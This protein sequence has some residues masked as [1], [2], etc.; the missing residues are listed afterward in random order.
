MSATFQRSCILAVSALGVSGY[1]D[2]YGYYHGYGGDYNFFAAASVSYDSSYDYQ[3]EEGSVAD[4]AGAEGSCPAEGMCGV[5]NEEP[6]TLAAS[7]QAHSGRKPDSSSPP[8]Q[9]PQDAGT[10]TLVRQSRVVKLK[11][12]TPPARRPQEQHNPSW[13]SWRAEY[14]PAFVPS[15]GNSTKFRGVGLLKQA[16]P[17]DLRKQLVSAYFSQA[18]NCTSACKQQH[19]VDVAGSNFCGVTVSKQLADAVL[20]TAEKALRA[21]SGEDLVVIPSHGSLFDQKVLAYG[22]GMVLHHHV[23]MDVAQLSATLHLADSGVTESWPLEGCY[24]DNKRQRHEACRA[25]HTQPGDIVYYQG[26]RYEHGRPT[27][28]QG[29]W[30]LVTGAHFTTRSWMNEAPQKIRQF[31]MEVGARFLSAMPDPPSHW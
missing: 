19:A 22:R 10:P 3:W 1:G 4:Y 12:L 24:W 26:A 28:F 11:R 13:K 25:V 2:F 31:Y 17:E 16:I 14:Q 20:Q 21:A 8:M 15:V 6:E 30:M 18:P 29:D 5:A 7:R 23:D 9:Q 27:A